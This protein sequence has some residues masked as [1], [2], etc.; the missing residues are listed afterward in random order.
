MKNHAAP[1]ASST[2]WPKRRDRLNFGLNPHRLAPFDQFSWI[3]L[4]VWSHHFKTYTN[5]RL[6]LLVVEICDTCHT[7]R[8]PPFLVNGKAEG[9]VEQT[10]AV[11]FGLYGCDLST[12][13]S[14]T[15]GL[16]PKNQLRTN[17]ENWHSEPRALHKEAVKV[18]GAPS[19][20]HRMELL[21]TGTLNLAVTRRAEVY[22]PE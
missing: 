9:G 21:T 10:R 2:Q 17:I 19:H 22:Y 11:R 18:R 13:V 5:E 14:N 4:S 20:V 8:R 3:V 1:Y 6:L 16:K 15:I 7:H 12:K